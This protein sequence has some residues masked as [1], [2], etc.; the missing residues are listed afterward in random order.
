MPQW[1]RGF[2]RAILDDRREVGLA[3]G[4]QVAVLRVRQDRG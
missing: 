4:L 1:P 2:G 3:L